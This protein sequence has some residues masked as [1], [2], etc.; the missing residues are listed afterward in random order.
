MVSSFLQDVAAMARMPVA[1][2]MIDFAIF[3]I[4]NIV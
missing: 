3:F 1:M 2:M 4:Y